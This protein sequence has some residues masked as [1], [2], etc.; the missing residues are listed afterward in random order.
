MSPEQISRR[1]LI[2]GEPDVVAGMKG[3]G[4]KAW[5][6]DNDK[7]ERV[8]LASDSGQL[9]DDGH[10]KPEILKQIRKLVRITNLEIDAPDSALLDLGEQPNVDELTLGPEITDAGTTY[11]PA[12]TRLKRL[13]IKANLSAAGYAKFQGCTHITVL[14]ISG[15]LGNSKFTD[16]A[17]KAF[18]GCTKMKMLMLEKLPIHGSGLACVRAMPQLQNAYLSGST[19]TDSELEFFAGA[20]NLQSIVLEKTKITDDG[21]KHLHG[22]SKLQNVDLN[23]TQIT[24]AGLASLAGLKELYALSLEDSQVADAGLANLHDLPDLRQLELSGSQVTG[25]GLAALQQLPG[26]EVLKLSKTLV[27]DAGLKALAGHK[28]IKELQLEHTKVTDAGLAS[29]QSLPELEKLNLAGDNITDGGLPN[30][31]KCP[32]L[33]SLTLEKTKIT[34][35]G[36]EYIAVNFQKLKNLSLYDVSGVTKPGVEKLKK[37]LPKLDVFN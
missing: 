37:A 33:E 25:T 17:L 9:T 35:A 13:V 3:L 21:L 14:D 24:G 5:F 1:K 34:D 26:L 16:D 12:M 7:K 4:G 30:L 22:C 32:K 10:I 20:A 19:M 23:G 31:Q 18:A 6:D 36:L 8:G 2:E 11:L 29:L 28:R 15:E 27:G